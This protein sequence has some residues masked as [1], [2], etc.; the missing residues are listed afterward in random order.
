MAGDNYGGLP[1]A[2]RDG[3]GRGRA[4]A[5]EAAGADG[6]DEGDP[7]DETAR[8]AA[9]Q[10]KKAAPKRAPCRER[11][12]RR[13]TMCSRASG[14]LVGLGAAAVIAALVLKRRKK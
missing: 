1:D 5:R 3:E 2:D 6:P 14:I 12:P 7:S 4:E 10:P 13:A 9:G 8:V 11:C